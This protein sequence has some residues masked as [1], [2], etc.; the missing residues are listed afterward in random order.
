SA[1]G[2][3]SLSYLLR[4]KCVAIL[5]RVFQP[6]NAGFPSRLPMPRFR[7]IVLPL[8]FRQGHSESGSFPSPTPKES[9]NGHESETHDFAPALSRGEV[10]TVPRRRGPGRLAQ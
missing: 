3:R 2:G 1:A 10:G 8:P 6:R 9:T 5:H 4:K 7:G